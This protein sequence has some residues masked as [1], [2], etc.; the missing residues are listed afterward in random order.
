MSGNEDGPVVELWIRGSAPEPIRRTQRRVYDR[1]RTLQDGGPIDD[2]V[3]NR[4]GTYLYVEDDRG[5]PEGD[6]AHAAVAAFEQWAD[7]EDCDLEPGF[8]SFETPD[9][10]GRIGLGASR[11]IRLPILGLAV[12]EGETLRTVAPHT[13]DEGVY[14]VRDAMAAIEADIRTAIQ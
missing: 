5:P 9:D 3:A 10:G 8:R 6:P 1:L 2:V 11:V 4:W 14:T 12:Y 7:R 13:T